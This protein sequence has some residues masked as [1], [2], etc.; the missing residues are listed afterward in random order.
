MKAERERISGIRSAVRAAK[1]G[2]DVAEKFVT[3][4]TDLAKV[5][6]FAINA[7]AE[8]SDALP[9]V[10]S[11]LRLDV[12][13]QASEK[14]ARGAEAWLYEKA[15]VRSLIDAGVKTGKVVKPEMNG[16]EFRGASHADRRT[17]FAHRASR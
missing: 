12:G 1:L 6:E 15:G 14:F 5:R 7:M 10:D 4:G 16:A 8:R 13:E 17:P 3:D 11:H 9:Q 2:D